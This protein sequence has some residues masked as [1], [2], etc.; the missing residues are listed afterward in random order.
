MSEVIEESFSLNDCTEWN[1][2]YE[3]ATK[4]NNKKEIMNLLSE[5]N[6]LYMDEYFIYEI[7]IKLNNDDLTKNKRDKLIEQLNKS[8]IVKFISVKD[9]YIEINTRANCIKISKLS[10]VVKEI[11]KDKNSSKR[12]ERKDK[13]SAIYVSQVLPF[14]NSIVMGYVCGIC[15]KSK[16]MHTWVEFKNN[17][18]EDFVVDY[19]DNT[20]Y[21]KEGFYFLKHAEVIKKVDSDELR[22]KSS[23]SKGSNSEVTKEIIDIEIDM[24]DDR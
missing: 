6:H 21:N 14:Q 19:E 24:G 15:D 2:R 18:R 7:I 17:N 1:R 9:D 3:K 4:E 11:K 5:A 10:D 8:K 16:K 22:G 13:Y 20:I 23:V 12:V